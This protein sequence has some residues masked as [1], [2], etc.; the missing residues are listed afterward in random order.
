MVTIIIEINNQV[1]PQFKPMLAELF[2]LAQLA[3]F[4]KF[5]L[6]YR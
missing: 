3:Q 2:Q 6:G 1:F 5:I 4:D